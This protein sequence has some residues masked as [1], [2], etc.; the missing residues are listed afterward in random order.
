LIVVLLPAFAQFRAAPGREYREYQNPVNPVRGE[1]VIGLAI[2]PMNEAQQRA[3]S[4]QVLLPAAYSGEIHI[5]TASADG[6]FRGDGTFVGATKD[7]GWVSLPLTIAAPSDGKLPPAR[8]VNP[9]SLAIAARGSGGNMF[10]VRWGDATQVGAPEV[11]RLYVNSKRADT[12]VRAAA[13]PA[14]CKPIGVAQPIRFDSYCDVSMSD[15]A[16]DGQLSITRREQFD[17][18]TYTFKVQMP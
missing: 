11:V 2:A 8:P 9:L 5:E 18:Q 12:F 13:K 15:I 7:K 16:P 3:T 1:A 17:E 4:V 14:R 6:K 10:L